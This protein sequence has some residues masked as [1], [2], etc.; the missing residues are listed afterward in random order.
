VS[1]DGLERRRWWARPWRLVHAIV[2]ALG[3]E[4]RTRAHHLW[5]DLVPA[6]ALVLLGFVFLGLESKVDEQ[7]VDASTAKVEARIAK[8]LAETQ[9]NGRRISLGVT[10]GALRGVEDAGRLVLTNRLPGTERFVM[11]S[12]A[13]ER[14]IRR[15][16]ARAYN[17]VITD[18]IVQEAGVDGERVIEPN[19]SV[20]CERLREVARAPKPAP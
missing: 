7:G 10:C 12:S 2:L 13:R 11:P 17:R 20:N 16:F 9:S 3:Q 6:I 4:P 5:R 15:I 18:R 14:R 8:R 1:P 19:G